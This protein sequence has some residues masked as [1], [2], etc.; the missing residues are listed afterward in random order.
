MYVHGYWGK[1][2]RQ[3]AGQVT[4]VVGNSGAGGQWCYTSDGRPIYIHPNSICRYL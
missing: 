4:V 2:L 3:V 1:V